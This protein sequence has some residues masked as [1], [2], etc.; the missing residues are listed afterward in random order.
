[1][2]TLCHCNTVRSGKATAQSVR[3]TVFV[4]STLVAKNAATDV[5][6]GATLVFN[7]GIPL[8]HRKGLPW[9]IRLFA[10]GALDFV[11]AMADEIAV[12]DGVG[13]ATTSTVYGVSVCFGTY[14]NCFQL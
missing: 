5:G 11:A 10:F 6:D 7:K 12:G 2:V 13:T 8:N 1:M 4:G 3:Q 14:S 9:V